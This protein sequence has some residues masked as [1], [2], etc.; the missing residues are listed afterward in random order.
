MTIRLFALMGLLL[1]LAGV[2]IA[3]LWVQ[4]WIVPVAETDPWDQQIRLFPTMFAIWVPAIYLFFTSIWYYLSRKAADTR[5]QKFL[6]YDLSSYFALLV[7][8]LC[9]LLQQE[10]ASPI[11]VLKLVILFIF[12]VKCFLLFR[13]LYTIPEL[14][15]PW[16]LMVLSV[17]LYLLSLPFIHLSPASSIVTFLRS[18][19]LL[20]TGILAI[21]SLCI[22][23]M[24]IEMFR[25]SSAMTKSTQSAFFSWVIVSFSFPILNFPQLLFIL[26][27]LLIIFVLRLIVSRLD[28]RELIAGLLEPTSMAIGIKLLLVT[29]II[30]ASGLVFWS[31]A[32]PGFEFQHTKFWEASIGTLF[33]GQSGLFSYAPM[34]WL[35][36]F[37]IIY[38]LFFRGWN[39]ILLI[40]TGGVLYIGYHLINYGMLGK[41]IG[42]DNSIPFLPFF[43]VFIAIAHHRFGKMLLFRI[44]GS[45]LLLITCG[46]T[47]ALLLFVP[48]LSSLSGKFSQAQQM[49]MSVTDRDFSGLFPSMPYKLLT[50]AFFIWIGGISLFALFCCYCRT[51]SFVLGRVTGCQPHNTNQSPQDV[52]FFPK[53]LL[54]AL[55][56]GAASFLYADSVRNIPLQDDIR[57]SAN[58]PQYTLYLDTETHPHRL[59]KGLIITSRLTNCVTIP[60]NTPLLHVTSFRVDQQFETFT[61]K[62][63]RDTSEE[64]LH[65]PSIYPSMSHGRAALY[66]S[67]P[68]AAEDGTPYEAHEYY[69]KFRFNKPEQ[70][71]K[72]TFKILTAK[73]L[74]LPPGVTIRIGNVFLL[75]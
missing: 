49:L 5:G 36:L 8:F 1:V 18:E 41:I 29:A 60:H 72:I 27:G 44:W 24:M 3:F 32:R 73:D 42:R 14:I 17:G 68:L 58:T 16:L 21:K 23:G 55:L 48:E 12:V 63:G 25:L 28:T 69:T 9:Q 30:G 39:G 35:S 6:Q 52:S 67:R 61:I 65:H 11:S 46:I 57:L 75:E 74:E 53:I 62:A 40:V 66:Y 38:L 56:V 13:L 19:I 37:G 20:H 2:M 31:N 34:Y 64:M 7:F 10:F 33:N 54:F 15:H 71:Q 70:L 51:R 50:P 45:I 26:A 22:S 43:G 47:V 4:T 59:T